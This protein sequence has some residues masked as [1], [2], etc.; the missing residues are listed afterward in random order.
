MHAAL[1][2]IAILGDAL[3]LITGVW[4]LVGLGETSNPE[5]QE[6]QMWACIAPV[7]SGVALVALGFRRILPARGRP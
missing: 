6:L 4:S 7:S 2:I 1:N 3:T 5:V